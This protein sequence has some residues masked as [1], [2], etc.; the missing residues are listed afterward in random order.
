MRSRRPASSA[1][2]VAAALADAV[3]AEPLRVLIEGEQQ[4]ALAEMR[5][6]IHVRTRLHLEDVAAAVVRAVVDLNRNPRDPDER[7]ERRPPSRDAPI[8]IPAWLVMSREIV[9]AVAPQ[10]VDA[11]YSGRE[12]FFRRAGTDGFVQ[13]LVVHW[14]PDEQPDETFGHGRIRIGYGVWV[15]GAR[16][17]PVSQDPEHVTLMQATLSTSVRLRPDP[18]AVAEALAT[19]VL[20]WLDATDGRD[21]LA[22]WA[23]QDPGWI[24][25]PTQRP[26]WPDCSPSGGIRTPR[27]EST[28][29]DHCD[30]VRRVVGEPA[31]PCSAHLLPAG[32]PVEPHRVRARRHDIEARGE[33]TLAQRG[34]GRRQQRGPRAGA[35][36]GQRGEE[37]RDL[38]D[39]VVPTIVR[40]HPGPHDLRVTAPHRVRVRRAGDGDVAHR[41]PVGLR[42]PSR[43]DARPLEELLGGVGQWI[44]VRVAGGG[45]LLQQRAGQDGDVLGPPGAD[46]RWG[47]GHTS[48][49]H[50]VIDS[51]RGG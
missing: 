23:A 17:E 44:A 15:P 2:P 45:L 49:L 38:A 36:S 10:I 24:D 18:S 32:P 9:D 37:D 29:Q 34:H 43:E 7:P 3:A 46:G 47:R 51:P 39:L 42:D 1:D 16:D 6:W 31:R 22:A 14:S 50:R 5:E 19:I 26:W 11:G 12:G 21:A 4:P 8:E 28:R 35:A 25:P 48:I 33:V 27:V 40:R 20:P 41:V 13:M 30:D